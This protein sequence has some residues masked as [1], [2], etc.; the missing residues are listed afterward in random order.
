MLCTKHINQCIRIIINLEDKRENYQN[1]SVLCC[2]R[3]LCTMI[4]P[5]D[6]NTG[7]TSLVIRN[8]G[9]REMAFGIKSAVCLL[10]TVSWLI[11][12]E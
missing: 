5:Y 4:H 6:Y 9:V 8:T 11:Q 1:C 7:R 2:V 3:Q 12:K 10:A